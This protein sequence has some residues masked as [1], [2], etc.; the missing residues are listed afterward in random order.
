MEV[1]TKDDKILYINENLIK[2]SDFLQTLYENCEDENEFILKINEK[3]LLKLIEFADNYEKYPF[4]IEN[5]LTP[6]Q[7]DECH[8][9][10][11]DNLDLKQE[12]FQLLEAGNFLLIEEIMELCKMKICNVINT[13]TEKDL[14]KIFELENYK[15]EE[16]AEAFSNKMET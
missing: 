11:I 8:N 2:M 5:K 7:L 12:I 13:Q 1:M 16:E 15:T 14:I 10:F 4:D 6:G 9:N 3:I